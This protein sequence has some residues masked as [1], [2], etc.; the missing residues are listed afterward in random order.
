MTADAFA[1]AC[2]DAGVL[3]SGFGEGLVR[4]CTHLDVTAADVD[5]AVDRIGDVVA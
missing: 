1:A 3:C 4:L 5:D 2:E